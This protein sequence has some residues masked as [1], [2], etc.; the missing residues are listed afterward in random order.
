MIPTAK[1]SLIS[2]DVAPASFA[3]AKAWRSQVG[4]P[5]A[6][7]HPAWISLRV[8]ASSTSSHSKST[9]IFLRVVTFISFPVVKSGRAARGASHC[10]WL[11]GRDPSER[12]IFILDFLLLRWRNQDLKWLQ[13]VFLDELLVALYHSRQELMN[14]GIV[15]DEF[16]LRVQDGR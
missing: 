11:L 16:D 2:A 9:C 13:T 1:A 8:L 15:D 7:A 6:T 14:I 4:Q 10:K 3:P 12:N 5:A